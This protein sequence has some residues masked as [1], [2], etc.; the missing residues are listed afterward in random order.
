M[1]LY[2]GCAMP[3]FHPQHLAV[4]GDPNEWVWVDK[5]IQHPQVK[6]WDATT[7]EEVPMLSVSDIYASH[8]LEH[9]P[10]TQ[11]VDILKVWNKRLVENGKLTINVP[12]LLWAMKQLNKLEQG[13][14]LDGYYNTY[15][16]EH[17]ILS[18]LYGSQSHEGEIH[19]GGFT[20]A[21]LRSVLE[22]A[23]FR[24]ITITQK[25]E[26]HDMNCLIATAYA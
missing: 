3:P 21:Y 9:F 22:Q 4:L 20:E 13:A 15:A 24:N 14:Q 23:K 11:I 6:N 8:L 19:K 25:V 5:Y 1:K 2:L 10:H 16:G 26:A 18:I 12:D 17:G 7:L